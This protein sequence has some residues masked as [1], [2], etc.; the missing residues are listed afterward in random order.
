MLLFGGVFDPPHRAHVELP[1]SIRDRLLGPRAW[2]VY[3]PAARSPHKPGGP[4]AGDR[5]RL[6]M[7][8]LATAGVDRCAVWMEEIN[9][10]GPSFWVDTLRRAVRAAPIGVPIRFLIGSDQ[11]VAFHRWRRFRQILDLAEPIVMLRPPHR[12]AAAVIRAMKRTGVWT[13]AELEQ[14][15]MW[16]DDASVMDASST[17]V[18]RSIAGKG[19]ASLMA[20]NVLAYI[21]A[22]G[23]YNNGPDSARSVS[24][25][26][27]RTKRST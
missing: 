2:L 6:R 5:D 18:R 11:A 24:Q 14:W 17:R 25:P 8:R 7:L 26:P 27:R 4:V 22:R 3:V 10:G 20:C 9:R 1:L 15:G 21:N 16:I 23:L 19:C 12:S 13:A